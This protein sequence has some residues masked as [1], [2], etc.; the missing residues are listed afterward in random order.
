MLN[1]GLVDLLTCILKNFPD[2]LL[3]DRVRQQQSRS[4]QRVPV[5]N[6]MKIAL[7]QLFCGNQEL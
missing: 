1:T 3:Y 6:I 7:R 4:N 5:L 2:V